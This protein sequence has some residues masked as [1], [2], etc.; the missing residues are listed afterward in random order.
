MMPGSNNPANR[1]G[2]CDQQL[3]SKANKSEL[4]TIRVWVHKVF[5]HGFRCHRRHAAAREMALTRMA[6]G[7][8]PQ[9]SPRLILG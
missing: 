9:N 4:E 5:H 2:I 8:Y 3:V 7:S 6:P 1:A